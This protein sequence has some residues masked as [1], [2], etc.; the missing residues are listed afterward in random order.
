MFDHLVH[1]LLDDGLLAADLV[2]GDQPAEVV[3]VQQRADLQH[4]AEPA[5]SL[6][7]AAA[8]DVEGEVRR[9]EPVVQA[10]L[11]GLGPVRQFRKAHALVPLVGEGVHQQTVAAGGAEGIEDDDLPLGVLL[12]QE[13]SRRTGGVVD[14]GD[15]RGQGQVQDVLPL[16]EER[17]E[18]VDELFDVDLGRAGHGAVCHLLVERVG[19]HGLVQVVRVLDVVEVVVEADIVDVPLLKFFFREV[20]CGAAAQDVISHCDGPPY[21]PGFAGV[22]LLCTYC[23]SS[24]PYRTTPAWAMYLS[25]AD[26]TV[27]YKVERGLSRRESPRFCYCYAV[28]KAQSANRLS[29]AGPRCASWPRPCSRRRRSW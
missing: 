25:R 24:F 6:G 22:P 5:G 7:D 15:A 9:E 10:E 21:V 18:V 16:F 17:R 3:H 27:L 19:V 14:A 8:A 1:D 20:C 4:R 26:S 29:P 11:V 28:F 23:T 13:V 12:E 2:A